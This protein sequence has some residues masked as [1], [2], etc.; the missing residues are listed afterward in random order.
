MPVEF[1]SELYQLSINE[2]I[3]QGLLTKVGDDNREIICES[4]E[5]PCKYFAI[6]QLN[7]IV[8]PHLT[9]VLV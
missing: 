4:E 1:F 3:D 7:Q 8:Y 9:Q 2:A 6:T 5:E